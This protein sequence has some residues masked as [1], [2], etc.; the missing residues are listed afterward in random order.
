MTSLSIRIHSLTLS[1]AGFIHDFIRIFRAFR[2]Q[3]SF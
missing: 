3:K 2:G 1:L